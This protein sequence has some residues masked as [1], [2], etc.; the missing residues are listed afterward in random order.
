MALSTQLSAQKLAIFAVQRSVRVSEDS[1]EFIERNGRLL[2]ST[3]NIYL[4]CT[5][6]IF[7]AAVS[8]RVSAHKLLE[9]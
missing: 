8:G 7:M 1:A 9:K 2:W 3:V 4:L 6:L 5:A